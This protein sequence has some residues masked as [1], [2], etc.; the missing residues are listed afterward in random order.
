MMMRRMCA[1]AGLGVAILAGGRRWRL[2]AAGRARTTNRA[3]GLTLRIWI[4]RAS[5]AMTFT[6]M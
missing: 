4:R 1:M 2:P 6:N 3:A 5:R